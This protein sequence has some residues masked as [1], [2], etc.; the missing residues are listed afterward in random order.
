MLSASAVLCAASAAA[1]SLCL[2]SKNLMRLLTA[3]L[4]IPVDRE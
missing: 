1:V 4:S 2:A 3:A